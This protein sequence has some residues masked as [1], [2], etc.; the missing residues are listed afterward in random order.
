MK[1][2]VEI[3]ASND[4]VIYMMDEWLRYNPMPE[5]TDVNN[6][7]QAVKKAYWA[8]QKDEAFTIFFGEEYP[9]DVPSYKWNIEQAI[10]NRSPDVSMVASALD[11]VHR[12]TVSL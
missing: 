7:D 2:L 10:F 3:M 12:L 1:T 9:L 11:Y 6:F 8:L 4:N 5:I